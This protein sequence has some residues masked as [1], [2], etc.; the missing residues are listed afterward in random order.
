MELHWLPLGA[1]GSFVRLNGRAFEAAQAHLDGRTPMDLYH[2][3]LT[4]HCDGVRTVVEMTPS[5]GGPGTDRGVVVTGPVGVRGVA[6][7]KLLRYEIRCWRDGSISDIGE[8]AGDPLRLSDSA[9]DARRI[10]ALA[11]DVPPLTWGRDE[12]NAGEMWN[13]NSVIAW[14]VKRA[15]LAAE[16]VRPPRGGRAPGWRAGVTVARHREG[17]SR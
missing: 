10:I 14:L 17:G 13:S 16:Q 5:F 6:G 7:V 15:G 2:S 9:D 8:A 11:P 12:R 4:L 1:G 3:A